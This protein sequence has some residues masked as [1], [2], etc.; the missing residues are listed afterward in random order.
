MRRKREAYRET[1]GFGCLLP[2]FRR[3]EGWGWFELQSFLEISEFNQLPGF[4]FC[5]QAFREEVKA[6]TTDPAVCNRCLE[7]NVYR[8]KVRYTGT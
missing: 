3:L 5:D 8:Q 1:P 7:S 2:G 4:G 6:K